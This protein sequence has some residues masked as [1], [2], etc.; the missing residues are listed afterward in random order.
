MEIATDAES[1]VEVVLTVAAEADATSEG[2]KASAMDITASCRSSG[3][4]RCADA[5]PCPS[6]AMSSEA[7]AA[8]AGV[9]AITEVHASGSAVRDDKSD[10]AA[11]LNPGAGTHPRPKALLATTTL[12]PKL[13]TI[14][15]QVEPVDRVPTDIVVV[16]ST[17]AIDWVDF[18]ESRSLGASV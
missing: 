15:V 8:T 10:A 18:E 3:L 9:E 7:S 4:P 5:R 17:S 1:D 6:Q 13:R 12:L 2:T 14:A 11:D 16:V